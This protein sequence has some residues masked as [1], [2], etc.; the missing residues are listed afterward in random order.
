MFVKTFVLG[1]EIFHWIIGSAREKYHHSQYSAASGD[2][3]QPDCTFMEIQPIVVWI[4]LVQIKVVHQPTFP[5]LE[6]CH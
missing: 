1:V 5:V 2:Y 6:P 4:F 3:E